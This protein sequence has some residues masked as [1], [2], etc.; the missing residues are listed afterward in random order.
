MGDNVFGSLKGDE[1]SSCAYVDRRRTCSI[2]RV[3]GRTGN[4]N[5]VKTFCQRMHT[6][7][8]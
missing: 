7:V 6:R 4:C 1:Y 2:D 8:S 3:D 5:N